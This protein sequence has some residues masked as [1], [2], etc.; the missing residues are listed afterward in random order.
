MGGMI[1]RR[2]SCEA[3]TD[4]EASHIGVVDADTD[5]TTAASAGDMATR[6]ELHSAAGGGRHRDCDARA[7]VFGEGRDNTGGHLAA[8]PDGEARRVECEGLAS[9]PAGVVGAFTVSAG[10]RDRAANC[11]GTRYANGLGADVKLSP[12]RIQSEGDGRQAEASASA[13]VGW[14]LR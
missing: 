1:P 11:E 8:F 7:S 9:L 2:A 3:G 5:C 10:Q 4:A 13:G 14:V 6:A 12:R